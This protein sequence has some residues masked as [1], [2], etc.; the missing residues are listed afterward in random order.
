MEQNGS[1]LDRIE[2]L[3]ESLAKSGAE[4]DERLE[5]LGEKTDRRINA[6]LETMAQHNERLD[7]LYHGLMLLGPAL[8]RYAE[9]TQL[10]MDALA[11]VQRRTESNLNALV[12]VV[13]GLV[14]RPP[15]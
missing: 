5:S 12:S 15:Q 2:H 6:M 13:D 1:R 8:D 9:S 14:R 7:D 4:T 3:V 11:E 10:R